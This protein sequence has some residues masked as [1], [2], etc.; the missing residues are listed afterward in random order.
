MK[1]GYYFEIGP[2]KL[3]GKF[4]TGDNGRTKGEER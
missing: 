4:I 2:A 1:N 3:D